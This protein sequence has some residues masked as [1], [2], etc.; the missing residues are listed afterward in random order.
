MDSAILCSPGRRV[1]PTPSPPPEWSGLLSAVRPGSISCQTGNC[2]KRARRIVHG[3]TGLQHHVRE[4]WPPA[5]DCFP[6]PAAGQTSLSVP[7]RAGSHPHPPT[8]CVR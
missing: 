3:Q 8:P 4:G 2:A 5:D 7:L 6:D 1:S